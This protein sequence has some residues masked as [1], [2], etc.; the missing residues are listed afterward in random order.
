MSR[1]YDVVCKRLVAYREKLG[2]S[3]SQMSKKMGIGQSQYSKMETGKLMFPAEIL[4]E[5]VD[6]VYE[7]DYI[8]TGIHFERSDALS[9]EIFAHCEKTKEKAL[10][11][12]ILLILENKLPYERKQQIEYHLLEQY[13]NYSENDFR[14]FQE[15]R[16]IMG[17]S[18]MTMADY[19]GVNIKKYRQMEK[20][21]IYPDLDVML[22]I[23]E[24]FGCRPS[25]FL[26]IERAIIGLLEEWWLEFVS[27]DRYLDYLKYTKEVL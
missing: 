8:V 12:V 18:Q 3:Q 5:I 22:E 11:K 24:R 23:Y 19:L 13:L 2:M 1:E 17:I 9:N 6:S 4:L 16:R 14:I 27:E 20:G 25:F 21:K 10:M 7:V 15:C 26:D